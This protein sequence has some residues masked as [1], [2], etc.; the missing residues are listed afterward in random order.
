MDGKQ[1]KEKDKNDIE[2]SGVVAVDKDNEIQEQLQSTVDDH[3]VRESVKG[4]P[5]RRRADQWLAGEQ[6]DFKP[7]LFVFCLFCFSKSMTTILG[8]SIVR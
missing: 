7:G 4:G 3:T 8:L 2:N 5:G 1:E 6:S